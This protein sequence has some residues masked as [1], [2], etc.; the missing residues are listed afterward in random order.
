M[1]MRPVNVT[2]WWHIQDFISVLSKLICLVFKIYCDLGAIFIFLFGG[3]VMRFARLLSRSFG[4]LLVSCSLLSNI[5]WLMD[6]KHSNGGEY[7]LK[8][9]YVV[10]LL[11]MWASR[12]CWTLDQVIAESPVLQ[13]L[14][15]ILL[16]K[17]Y[18]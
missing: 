14:I 7:L 9:I 6:L 5:C 18:L 12:L 13:R 3:V 10:L 16:S 1:A 8:L 11:L 2:L 15:E 4:R 17:V